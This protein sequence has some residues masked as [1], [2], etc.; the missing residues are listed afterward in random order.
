MPALWAFFYL[1]EEDRVCFVLVTVKQ[2]PLICVWTFFC[3]DSVCL[4]F[5]CNTLRF[6]LYADDQNSVS[7]ACIDLWRSNGAVFLTT[8]C[9]LSIVFVD[10]W[11]Y[12]PDVLA[13]EHQGSEKPGFFKNAQPSGFYWVWALLGFS[14]FFI[15]MSSWEAC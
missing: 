6:L 14:D 4:S 12:Q 9:R 8:Q 1:W 3:V 2:H 7:A 13:L 5:R 15:W 11:Y 10:D